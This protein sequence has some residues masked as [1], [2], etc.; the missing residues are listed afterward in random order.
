MVFF[1]S[2]KNWFY[3]ECFRVPPTPVTVRTDDNGKKKK[4][5]TRCRPKRVTN[6]RTGKWKCITRAR[7][8]G[9][10]KR[11]TR[12]RGRRPSKHNT[13][14]GAAGMGFWDAWLCVRV[15][16]L[17]VRRRTANTDGRRPFSDD[18]YRTRVHGVCGLHFTA[19][20]G[21][22]R[23]RAPRSLKAARNA[24]RGS[25][26]ERRC[27]TGYFFIF[28]LFFLETPRHSQNIRR[29]R[30]GFFFR[31]RVSLNI[32]WVLWIRRMVRAVRSRFSRRQ[33]NNPCKSVSDLKFRIPKVFRGVEKARVSRT[34]RVPQDVYFLNLSLFKRW[35]S[36]L[37]VYRND[38]LVRPRGPEEND[39]Y[40]FISRITI[41]IALRMKI[42]KKKMQ[43]YLY[44][45]ACLNRLMRF[46]ENYSRGQKRISCRITKLP[47][48]ID[49]IFSIA[50]HAQRKPTRT[51]FELSQKWS[52]W[53][54][55]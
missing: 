5:T 30:E 17:P 27:P 25:L 3:T 13:F 42:C 12:R 21:C 23:F 7:A 1:S 53:D 35:K 2:H 43:N 50:H 15:R 54:H 49:S 55:Y 6:L 11:V 45:K 8:R 4:I 18:A 52:G 31:A 22:R 46:N 32:R 40:C 34:F 20:L 37:S 48:L 9:P 39:F 47:T 16:L 38:L 33:L 19:K 29:C 14:G 41:V 24:E 10:Q 36:W 28:F 51:D 44:W 26:L